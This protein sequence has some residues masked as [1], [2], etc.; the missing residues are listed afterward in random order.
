MIRPVENRDI[1][2]ICAIY[3]YYIANTVIT[4]EELPV[5]NLDMQGRIAE[6]SAKYLWVVYE[7]AQQVLGY[8][9]IGSWKNRAGYRK[10]AETTVYLA[11]DARGKGIG[12]QL[13][14]HL[15][16]YAKSK[17][18][19]ILIGGISLP[20]AESEGLHAYFGFEKVAH[21][22][23]VGYKFEQWVDVGYWQLTI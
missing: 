18:L 2:A 17:D 22:K 20:N 5:S 14:Q 7:Q 1:D 3:N 4:L 8:A 12:K 21:F 16:D 23:K 11:N 19:H 9:Y 13:Y 10:T 6:V 15:I